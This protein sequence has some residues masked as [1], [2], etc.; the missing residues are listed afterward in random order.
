[1]TP[2]EKMWRDRFVMMNLVRIGG[3]AVVLLGLAI[4]YGDLLV[5]GGSMIVGLPLA[6]VGLVVS[7]GAPKWL[8]AKWR[9]PPGQ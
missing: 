8:S 5:E 7:F 1:M 9:T 6:L 2:D 4:W 3:T